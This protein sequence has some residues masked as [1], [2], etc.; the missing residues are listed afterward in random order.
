MIYCILITGKNEDRYKFVNIAIKNFN[1][2]THP[3]K[4]L[5]II[6]H[7]NKDLTYL[8]SNNVTH[9]IFDKLNEFTLGD[10][11]NFSLEMIPYG[12][13]WTIWDDDDWR[14]SKYLELLYSNMINH[15]AD[16]VFFK[17]RID[18]NINNNFAYRSKFDNGMPFILSKKIETIQYLSKDSLED[19]R[20][21][22]DYEL[23]SRKIHIIN[24]DPRWY[25]RTIHGKNTSLYVDYEKNSI[26]N[27][28]PESLY[29][30]FDVT[31]KE[32]AYAQKIID[33]HFTPLNI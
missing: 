20:L 19:I 24:N 28:S 32:R 30:E 9:I 7:G 26:V 31:P 1:Q 8:E 2:Q 29:H 16:V 27:Y 12:A 21:Y 13:L 10:M 25:I 33:I 23:F 14:H 15:K 18:F 11:R 3:N 5:I 17:N 6:N 22:N 4:H